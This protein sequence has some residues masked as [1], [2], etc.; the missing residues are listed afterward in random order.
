MLRTLS[1]GAQ[2][3]VWLVLVLTC[4]LPAL[5]LVL[6]PALLPVYFW[7]GFRLLAVRAD[8]CGL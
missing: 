6:L 1:Q 7:E 5:L 4:Q 3:P 8:P 2:G